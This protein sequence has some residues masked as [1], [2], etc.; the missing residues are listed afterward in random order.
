M[1]KVLLYSLVLVGLPFVALYCVSTAAS[2]AS[3]PP[4]VKQTFT[5]PIN[6]LLVGFGLIGFGS[7]IKSKTLR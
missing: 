5:E 1:K 3:A 7:F 4:I 2:I 6:M